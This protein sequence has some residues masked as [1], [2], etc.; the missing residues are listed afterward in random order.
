[1]SQSTRELLEARIIELGGSIPTPCSTFSLL[2]NNSI[3]GTL[4][5]Q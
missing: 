1:M 4:I 5:N 2:Y 3:H